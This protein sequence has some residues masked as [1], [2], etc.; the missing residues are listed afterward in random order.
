MFLLNEVHEFHKEEYK[1]DIIPSKK[2]V[3]VRTCNH[4]QSRKLSVN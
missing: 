4:N 1:D 2:V 3:I